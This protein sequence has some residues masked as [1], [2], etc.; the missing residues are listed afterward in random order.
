MTTEIIQQQSTEVAKKPTDSAAV[1]IDKLKESWA[2]VLP[3]VCTPDR[4]ARVALTCL[5]K[6]QKL[7]TAIQTQQGRLSLSEQFMKCAELGIEPD[8]RRAYLIPYKNEVQLIIDY[9]GIAELAMRSGKI[10]NI[11]ADK[12]CEND[13]FEY[14]VG[15]IEK[16]RIDF[17][18][19]RGKAYAYYAIVTFKDGTKKCE[20]MSKA[21]IDGIRRRSKSANN[22]PW[23]TDY[24]EMAKKT[25][26][27]RLSKWLPQSPEMQQAFD[28]DDEDFAKGRQI[29]DVPVAPDVAPEERYKAVEIT[30]TDAEAQEIENESAPEEY[31]EDDLP[32]LDLDAAE[33]RNAEA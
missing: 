6:N 2:L 11:H 27:R 15:M 3:K 5:R 20:V 32:E 21:E 22:G 31:I 25:V 28:I 23:V 1:F 17:K 30:A 4:F 8:G 33:D 10:S 12:V 29:V 16:H 19:E 26:F 9:K 18:R 24:D 7:A 14:N 13:E